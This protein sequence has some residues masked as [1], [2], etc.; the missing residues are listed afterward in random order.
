MEP[1]QDQVVHYIFD[2]Q[3]DRIPKSD[4][5]IPNLFD[6][7]LMPQ[8]CEPAQHRMPLAGDDRENDG[9]QV[10]HID[11]KGLLPSGCGSA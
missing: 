4:H 7:W 8:L 3:S 6:F 1:L 2:I 9:A 11:G 5:H 10:F